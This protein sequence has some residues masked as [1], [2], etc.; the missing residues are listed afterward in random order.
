MRHI[1][2]AAFVLLVSSLA[3][4]PALSHAC[5]DNTRE[6]KGS[7]DKAVFKTYVKNKFHKGFT[8][9]VIR[10][11]SV[12][13]Q[14]TLYTDEEII[15]NSTVSTSNTTL[16]MEVFFE[17][18]TVGNTSQTSRVSCTFEYEWDYNNQQKATF[19]DWSCEDPNG[20]ICSGCSLECT[21][22]SYNNSKDEWNVHFR[23]LP[24]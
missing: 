20:V 9:G 3:A 7:T 18:P 21:G 6:G 14:K 12:K 24:D 8:A 15:Q 13:E 4:G 5:H 11:G 19:R 2:S 1:L 22:T 10:N 23:L 17:G 16:D